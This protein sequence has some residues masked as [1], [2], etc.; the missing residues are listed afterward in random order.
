MVVS[1]LYLTRILESLDGLPGSPWSAA[2]DGIPGTAETDEEWFCEGV[3]DTHLCGTDDQGG[4]EEMHDLIDFTDEKVARYVSSLDPD[5]VRAI[6]TEPQAFRNPGTPPD[7][8]EWGHAYADDSQNFNTA[9]VWRDNLARR[10]MTWFRFT[11]HDDQIYVDGWRVQ[12]EKEAA[13]MVIERKV[14]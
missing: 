2:I 1:D 5:T 12:P 4:T 3:H 10:G 8:Q 11:K 9:I 6:V 7:L 13:F 14:S